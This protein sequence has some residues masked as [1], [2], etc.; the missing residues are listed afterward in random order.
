MS[1]APRDGREV[2]CV[3]ADGRKVVTRWIS[4]PRTID[5]GHWEIE[6]ADD[7]MPLLVGWMPTLPE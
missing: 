3:T 6:A 1:Q 7:R 4:L 2:V 5:G